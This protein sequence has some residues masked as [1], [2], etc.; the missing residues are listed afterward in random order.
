LPGPPAN[1]KGTAAAKNLV[2]ANDKHLS[3]AVND[4]LRKILSPPKEFA[5]EGA[6]FVLSNDPVSN[7][8]T[9]EKLK[10]NIINSYG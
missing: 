10:L 4:L 8:Y 7:D 6:I 1:L 5:S 2:R 3:I 9:E